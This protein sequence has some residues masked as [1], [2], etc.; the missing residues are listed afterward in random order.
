M[1]KYRNSSVM[2]D[3]GKVGNVAFCSV[4]RHGWRTLRAIMS[5]SAI[6]FRCFPL[7]CAELF[8]E[9]RDSG[10]NH[11]LFA[12]KL[13]ARGWNS[14]SVFW[15]SLVCRLLTARS[16]CSGSVIHPVLAAFCLFADCF[17]FWD[18]WLLEQPDC[19]F[20]Q[21]GVVDPGVA[22]LDLRPHTPTLPRPGYTDVGRGVNM[23]D[24]RRAE[25]RSQKQLS[26]SVLPE[27]CCGLTSG[28]LDFWRSPITPPRGGS[29]LLM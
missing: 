5:S 1:G 23:A 14:L 6:I 7:F 18:Y 26:G 21:T 28:K 9:D 29:H 3:S 2:L 25:N 11:I 20:P 13:T 27:R 15:S 22:P 16:H 8:Q 4:N 10:M 12:E 17:T 24:R 19:N